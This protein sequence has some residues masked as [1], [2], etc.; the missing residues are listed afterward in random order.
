MN[1]DVTGIVFFGLVVCNDN[2][3]TWGLKGL[4]VKKRMNFCVFKI[5]DY[6]IVS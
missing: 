5:T 4:A 1:Y 2:V 3:Q 6:W